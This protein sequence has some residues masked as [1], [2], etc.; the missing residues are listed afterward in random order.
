M[1]AELVLLRV[2]F[3]LGLWAIPLAVGLIAHLGAWSPPAMAW[4][5]AR[6]A[7]KTPPISKAV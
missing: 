7:L 6:P 4:A 1:N 5:E 3:V 2:A